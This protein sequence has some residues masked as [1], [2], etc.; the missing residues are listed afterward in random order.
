GEGGLLLRESAKGFFAWAFVGEGPS[1]RIV[2]L[3]QFFSELLLFPLE[4]ASLLPH[5]LHL[6][7]EL[8]GGRAA[9]FVAE[10]FELFLGL[11]R[12]A[13]SLAHVSLLEL[14]GGLA[15]FL[16]GLLKLLARFGHPGLVLSLRHAL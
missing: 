1:S 12:R 5:L 15:R 8:G 3:L 11:G 14:L 16:A 10:F 13:E 6:F 2:V 4:F 7:G 9:H